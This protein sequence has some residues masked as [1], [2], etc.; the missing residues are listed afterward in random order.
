VF[1]YRAIQGHPTKD[2]FRQGLEVMSA[3]ASQVQDNPPEDGS[4][5]A[6]NLGIYHLSDNERVKMA[7]AAFMRFGVT[8][9]SSWQWQAV[10]EQVLPPVL[11]PAANCH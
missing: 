11:G 6:L 2:E 3:Y 4:D 1:T 8:K 5:A 9:P 10:C 7:A